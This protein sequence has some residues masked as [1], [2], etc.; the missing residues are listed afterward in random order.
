MKRGSRLP[1]RLIRTP[2]RAARIGWYCLDERFALREPEPVRAEKDNERNIS[3]ERPKKRPCPS[4]D[5]ARVS[6]KCSGKE[7]KMK[8]GKSGRFRKSFTVVATAMAVILG[9][10][11]PRKFNGIG[12]AT[13]GAGGAAPSSGGTAGTG[14]GG[15]TMDAGA[16]VFPSATG[17]VLGGSG[18]DTWGGIGGMAGNG[19][20]TGG[21]GHDWQA[22]G[23]S[24]SGGTGVGNAA[25]GGGFGAGG[26]A[27]GGIAGGI[28][29]GGSGSGGVST[30][31]AGTGGTGG[32]GT[33]GTGGAGTGGTGAAGTG[34]TGGAGTGGAPVKKTTGTACA[35]D[36][37]DC[38]SGS[39]V[40]GF[41]CENACLGTCMACSSLKTGAT[42]G[43]CR[44]VKVMT[45]PDNDCSVDNG[46]ACGRDGTCDGLGA[47]RLQVTGITCGSPS[48]TGT[49]SPML[50]P[51]GKCNGSGVC[52]PSTTSTPCPNNLGCASTTA[53][54]GT[55]TER[56]STGCASGFKCVNGSCAG[57]TVQQCGS[58]ANC[59]VGNGGQCCA[60]GAY[61][62]IAYTCQPPGATC[63][64]PSIII[65]D[66]RS[67]CPSSQICCLH[68]SGSAPGLWYT[69]CEDPA[70]CQGHSTQGASQVCDTA[71]TS[72]TEC[73]TGA[74]HPGDSSGTILGLPICY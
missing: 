10:S 66:S 33:G 43:L 74:C 73:L 60:T 51:A 62:S 24:S 64:T 29:T 32:A 40:D 15:G 54:A 1:H 57:A 14:P 61:Q 23:G 45:D 70:A 16:D 67:E 19:G 44:P 71:F 12:G 18:G 49:T 35:N 2:R 5:V 63:D 48:C 59:P 56:S 21:G 39:C 3:R 28:S 68:S 47:C 41:C 22:V 34:S 53:C 72:P 7:T 42:N 6:H 65:C 69:I 27:A 31:G 38:A 25:G 37:N 58:V 4:T 50:T 26:M 13:G 46:N 8:P 55:C 20:T 36:N 30:G 17:G 9:C 11:E 52:I